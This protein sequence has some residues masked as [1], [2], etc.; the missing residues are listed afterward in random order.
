MSADTPKTQTSETS[1]L[2]GQMQARRRQ[3]AELRARGLQPYA[4]DFKLPIPLAQLPTV[5][6]DLDRK[7]VG[8]ETRVPAAIAPDE[9]KL[10]DA[11]P[12]FAVAGRLV[13]VNEMGKARFLFV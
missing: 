12:R 13:Q 5:P 6:S 8:W 7:V 11:H 1:D 9:G 2:E 4:N 3:V 10:S